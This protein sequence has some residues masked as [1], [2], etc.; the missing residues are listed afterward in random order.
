MKSINHIQ[1]EIIDEFSI[2]EGDLDMCVEYLIELGKKLSPLSDKHRVEDNI[3]K[4]C[5]SKVWLIANFQQGTITFQA[6]SNTMI[7]KGLVSMLV[8][9]LSGQ[10]PDDILNSDLYFIHKIG[11]NRFIGTQRSNGLAAMIKQMKL[12]ALAFMAKEQ[13]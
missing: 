6:D 12:Y 9:I 5:Q 8:R 3:V 13:K 10:N 2:L 1:D 4:G 11:M 7:T